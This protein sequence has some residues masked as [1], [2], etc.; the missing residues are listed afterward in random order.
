MFEKSLFYFATFM[1]IFGLLLLFSAVN[2]QMQTIPVRLTGQKSSWANIQLALFDQCLPSEES[3]TFGIEFRLT[4][5]GGSCDKEGICYPSTLSNRKL[6]VMH[7]AD[8]FSVNSEL[9]NESK[10]A[11]IYKECQ[12]VM[13]A[14]KVTNAEYWHGKTDTSYEI[15][16]VHRQFVIHF[17]NAQELFTHVTIDD[18]EQIEI[19]EADNSICYMSTLRNHTL[20]V[21]HTADELSVNSDLFN[22]PKMALTAMMMMSTQVVEEYRE[23]FHEA[24]HAAACKINKHCPRVIF[25]S[26]LHGVDENGR[27]YRGRTI[28]AERVLFNKDQLLAQMHYFLGSIPGELAFFGSVDRS[29]IKCDNDAANIAAEAIVCF[30]EDAGQTFV[31]FSFTNRCD[32]ELRKEPEFIARVKRYI[33]DALHYLEAEFAKEAVRKIVRELAMKVFNEQTKTLL[34]AQIA[35]VLDNLPPSN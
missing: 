31:E 4:K 32:P 23:A 26:I 15:R 1:N 7:T 8:E 25:L 20:N 33:D 6:N 5:N 19:D 34:E 29:G 10:M 13:T 2:S 21:M 22:V 30:I 3:K 14:E 35:T 11:D 17:G 24:S 16:D 27:A 18:G 12:E 28:V 9:F